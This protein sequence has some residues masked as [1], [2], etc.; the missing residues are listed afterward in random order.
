MNSEHQNQ[1]FKNQRLGL[2]TGRFDQVARQ[3]FSTSHETGLA[4]SKL[5]GV[6]VPLQCHSPFFSLSE[7][8]YN[9]IDEQ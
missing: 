1:Y 9:G 5:K 7:V 3:G 6:L 2:E 4:E 8:I